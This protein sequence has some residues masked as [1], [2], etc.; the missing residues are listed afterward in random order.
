MI[1][2]ARIITYKDNP[3]QRLQ[4]LTRGPEI[5]ANVMLRGAFPHGR[6]FCIAGLALL[7]VLLNPLRSAAQQPTS[8]PSDWRKDLHVLS[9]NLPLLHPNFFFQVPRVVFDNAVAQL[10]HDIPSLTNEQV[11]VGMAEIVAMA[12]D[13]HTNLSLNQ[14]AVPFRSYPIRLQW[15]SDGIF[16]TAASPECRP[17]LGKKLIRIGETDIQQ[18]YEEVG[19]V[20]SQPRRPQRVQ[21]VL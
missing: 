4:D 17:A 15:F 2:P 13:A 20:I 19:K 9:T 1:A 11:I 14:C 18:V 5:S 7:V 8:K 10:D 21:T 6:S 16:V 12:G 3:L